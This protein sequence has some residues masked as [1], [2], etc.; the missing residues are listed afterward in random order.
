MI[1][2]IHCGLS[3]GTTRCG[4]F[5]DSINRRLQN[6]SYLCPGLFPWVENGPSSQA[7]G[8]CDRIYKFVLHS[9]NDE[10]AGDD[11]KMHV[12]YNPI[13]FILLPNVSA[14]ANIIH[15]LSS[16]LIHMLIRSVE[17]RIVVYSQ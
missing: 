9:E 1:G 8:E 10:N 11:K 5:F 4:R 3:G 13:K 7:S 2:N 15:Y 14:E 17:T 12:Q 6:W 16:C